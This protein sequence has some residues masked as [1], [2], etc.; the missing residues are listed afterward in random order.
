MLRFYIQL[1]IM[2]VPTS[3]I[4]LK[5]DQENDGGGWTA[6][7]CDSVHARPLRQCTGE[8]MCFAITSITL[9][10]LTCCFLH[11]NSTML[12]GLSINR[13]LSMRCYRHM[14]TSDPCNDV[15]LEML[16]LPY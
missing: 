13:I 14:H 4:D 7:N 8:N 9:V 5:G 16:T 2:L 11:Y 6:G 12:M 1:S 10:Y 15:A 3:N